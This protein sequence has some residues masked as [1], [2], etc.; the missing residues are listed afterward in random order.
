MRP[1]C[2]L[3]GPRV[4]LRSGRA[5]DVQGL[6]RIRSEA[7][8]STWWGAPDAGEEAAAMLLDDTGEQFLVIEVAGEV[9][10]GISFSEETEPEYRHASLD[11]YLSE[12]VAGQ[13][14]GTEAVTV[15]AC[16]LVDECGH[17]RLTIDPAVANDRAVRSYLKVGF[18]PVGVLR[19]YERGADGTWHDGLL[20]DLLAP[21]LVRWRD[22]PPGV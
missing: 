9:V 4:L 6:H 1:A 13:G 8:V 2:D 3:R 20:M 21:E 22:G 11:L 16:W 18:K 10:G 5:E 15:L 7:F 12:H 19:E 17:H 14:L